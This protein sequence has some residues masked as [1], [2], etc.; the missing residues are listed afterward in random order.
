MIKGNIV[1]SDNMAGVRVFSLDGNLIL[2]N[3]TFQPQ[4]GFHLM[5]DLFRKN[6][7]IYKEGKEFLI[8]HL[9][10]MDDVQ[11]VNETFYKN[12]KNLLLTDLSNGRTKQTLP[13]P[14]ESKFL[15]GKAFPLRI[16]GQFLF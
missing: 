7:V 9:D 2:Q 5:V 13:F 8:H 11:E 14:E 1:L 6:Q 4:T 3:R 16:S 10:L 12:R 15:S